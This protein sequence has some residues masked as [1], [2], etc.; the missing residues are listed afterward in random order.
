MPSPIN[1]NDIALLRDL[2]V[3]HDDEFSHLDA[4]PS[5]FKEILAAQRA[6]TKAAKAQEQA[7][8]VIKLYQSSTEQK[9]LLVKS[10]R[11]LRQAVQGN[12]ANLRRI[13]A[14]ERVSETT[15]NYLIL[16]YVQG[17]YAP[18]DFSECDEFNKLINEGLKNLPKQVPA[19]KAAKTA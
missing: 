7:A 9:E 15:G 12:I 17:L 1:G 3:K 13:E 14:A 2:S 18:F 16:A 11:E 19:K 8:A 4:T 6:A 5:Q 10:I